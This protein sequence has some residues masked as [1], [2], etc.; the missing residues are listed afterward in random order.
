MTSA[1]RMFLPN[2]EIVTDYPGAE[3][4]RVHHEYNKC[5]HYK[6]NTWE[7]NHT[8]FPDCTEQC[9]H[10]A[11][12]FMETSY[13]GR[14][15]SL[16]ERNGYDDSDFYAT[17]WDDTTDSPKEIEYASTRGWTYPNGAT[18]DAPE[19]IQAK[20]A[21]WKRQKAIEAT[22]AADKEKARKVEPNKA[23]KV[24]RG[25]K[26]KVGLLVNVLNVIPSKFQRHEYAAKIQLPTG[27]MLWTNVS[28]LEVANPEKYEHSPE[29][30]TQ[31]VLSRGY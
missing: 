13:V 25:R 11:P 30:I 7:A 10:A 29:E 22:L 6:E 21:A 14:V 19:E 28:N 2:V 8:R 3:I 31:N 5:P 27:E 1:D 9:Q 4:T 12:L 20:Y 24:V 23:C 15:I 16:R 17:V 26:I 18:I